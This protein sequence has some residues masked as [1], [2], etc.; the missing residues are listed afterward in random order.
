MGSPPK[1]NQ[2]PDKRLIVGTS[3]VR[4]AMLVSSVLTVPVLADAA[5]ITVRD[6]GNLQAAIDAA[7]PGDVIMLQ[8]GST[9]V[10][11]F[12]LPEKPGSAFITIRSSAADSLLPGPNT[13]LTP[14]QTSLLA[15]IKSSNTMSAL[16]TAPRAHHW[17][18]QFLEFQANSL[19][20]G[21]IIAFGDAN[22]TDADRVPHDLVIDRC[23][24]HGD[25]TVGQKRGVALNSAGTDIV[26]SYISD[27]K[28]AGQDSQ[29]ICGW[30]G[31]GPFRIENNYLE[32]AGENVLFGGADPKIPNLVP[33]D[34]VV[35]RNHVSKPTSWRGTS[36]T[37]KNLFEL[38]NAQRVSI[39]YN[40]FENNWVAGQVGYAIVLTPRNQ[41]GGAPWTILQDISFQSNVVRHSAA[42]VNLLGRDNNY[43]SQLTQRVS[44]VN[45]LFYDIDA[46]RWGGNGTFMQIGDGPADVAV[47]HN[48]IVHSGTV[49]LAYGGTDASPMPIPR[50]VYCNNFSR[51]NEY[52]VFGVG[53]SF[54][55]DTLQNY[56][57]GA[58]FRRN[59]IAGAASSRY[60]SDNYYPPT[61]DF[62]RQFVSTST[63]NY[64][65]IATSPYTS[66]ATDGTAVGAN[67]PGLR[68]A[69]NAVG[70][71]NTLPRKPKLTTVVRGSE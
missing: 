35:R 56:F 40:V 10:G 50:F 31:P 22:E 67:V 13:R 68:G 42:G 26:N 16:T 66:S 9:F 11:N 61:D 37:V 48:T 8:A 12:R 53:R 60:P 27:I 70:T 17:R 44:I 51:H 19:G 33:S 14:A 32:A 41:D 29:A 1:H 3:V 64:Q 15:K 59:L 62:L 45:N 24:I 36:W 2:S 30:N 38:K 20:Y 43:P 55:N 46:A 4:L 28:F 18:L 63:D 65:L 34:I 57:P 25:P 71:Q 23:Y 39:E 58:D 49:I 47:S 52:G 7:Q 21:E 6:G 5:T 69:F 54:G